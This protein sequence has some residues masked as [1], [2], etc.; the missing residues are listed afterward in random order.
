MS[1]ARGRLMD[2]VGMAVALGAPVRAAMQFEEAFAD[3]EKVLDAPARKL[4]EIRQGLI[5]MSRE[6][7]LSAT[8]LTTIMAS[9]AQGGIPTEELERFSQATARAAVAFDMAA[10]EIGTRFAKLRNVYRLNQDQLELFADAANHLS[11][12]MA[13]TAAE[14][15]DFANRAAGAQRVLKLTAV[16]MNAVG[17]A[18]VAA[19]I[20]PETAARGVS[21]LANRLAQGG[22]KARGALKT[23]GL[24]YKEFMASIEADAPAAL[25]DLFDRLSKSPDGMTALIDLVGQDFSDD[26]SKLLNNPDLFAPGVRTG[27]QR[28]RLCRIGLAEYQKRAET[29]QHQLQLLTNRL[30]ALAIV[31]GDKLLEPI[32]A[33]I[34]GLGGLIDRVSAFA[35]L[36]PEL[37]ETLAKGTA[38]LLALVSP[39][40]LSAMRM[41]WSPGC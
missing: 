25:Q 18:M 17:A 13:A 16:Q 5:G 27:G 40:G 20:A 32:N 10:G 36:N 41:P 30:N 31:L 3:L 26:F 19:G 38:A 9:A 1:R 8:G 37:T 7:A 23:A 28:S 29:T 12:N 21:A 33:A 2:A 15:T 24:S 22:N 6:I 11:N 34:E 14:I 39:R 35:E 4:A